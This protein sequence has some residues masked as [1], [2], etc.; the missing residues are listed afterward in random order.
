MRGSPTGADGG[1]QCCRHDLEEP[2]VGHSALAEPKATS[3]GFFRGV[4]ATTI[5]KTHPTPTPFGGDLLAHQ[6]HP[7]TP[8][9][10][11]PDGSNW[12]LAD[13]R[14]APLFPPIHPHKG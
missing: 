7:N 8:P 3:A 11:G 13:A 5:E 9:E 1:Q 12:K 14:C 4:S 10:H 2:E 6:K